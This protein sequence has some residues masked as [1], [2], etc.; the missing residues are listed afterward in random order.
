V[1]SEL[2]LFDLDSCMP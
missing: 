1:I 2:I